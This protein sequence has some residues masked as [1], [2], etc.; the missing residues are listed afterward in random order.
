LPFYFTEV[1][2]AMQ[3]IMFKGKLLPTILII[4]C[5]VL[6]LLHSMLLSAEVGKSECLIRLNILEQLEQ[7][8]SEVLSDMNQEFALWYER[9]K[10]Q[11][12]CF[13]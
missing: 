4:T 2:V 13:R 12:F 8:K 9:L 6:F 5:N 10:S 1:P 3:K 11:F 7:C